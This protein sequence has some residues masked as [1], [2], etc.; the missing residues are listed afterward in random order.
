[1][2]VLQPGAIEEL[3]NWFVDQ[4]FQ[5]GLFDQN[6]S[7]HFLERTDG[8]HNQDGEFIRIE[9]A[10]QDE[11]EMQRQYLLMQSIPCIADYVRIKHP[12][13][14][15]VGLDKGD[16]DTMMKRMPLYIAVRERMPH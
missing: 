16:A 14:S 4:A 13:M 9:L 11:L 5:A 10:A 8:W 3:A 12:D 1:M 15:A 6:G 7:V 2:E